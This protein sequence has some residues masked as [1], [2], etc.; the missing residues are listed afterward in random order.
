MI[1]RYNKFFERI[2]DI[3]DNSWDDDATGYDYGNYDSS[4]VDPDPDSPPY[5]SGPTTGISGLHNSLS[6]DTTKSTYKREKT[7]EELEIDEEMEHLLYLLRTK[8]KNKGIKNFSVANRSY[9]VTVTSRM[10]PK[11]P[12][13]DVVKVFQALNSVQIEVLSGYSSQFDM[14]E[15]MKGETVFEFLFYLD[16]EDDGDYDDSK[17]DGRNIHF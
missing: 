1:K 8:L 16:A 3:W 6:S 14:Y 4:F 10:S 15:T 17:Y 2:D 13:V 9:D 12:L 11:E 7:P 5:N